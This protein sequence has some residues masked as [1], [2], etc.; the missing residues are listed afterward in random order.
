VSEAQWQARRR[1]LTEFVSCQDFYN[2][3][4]RDIEKRMEP[5]CIKNGLGMIPY[6]PLAGGLLGGAFRRGVEPEPGSRAA[7]RPTFRAWDTDRNWSVQERL[8][9]FAAERGWALPQMAVAWLLTRPMMATVIAGADTPEHIREN[10]RALEVKF[11]EADL[12]QIDEITLIDEDRTV[13]P[14]FRFRPPRS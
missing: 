1:G 8:R 5:F 11:S 9:D 13:A 6:F 4:Y 7:I 3:L 10:V 2:L 14:I 12:K